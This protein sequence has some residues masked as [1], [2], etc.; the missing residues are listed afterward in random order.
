MSHYYLAVITLLLISIA[1]RIVHYD[2]TTKSGKT[3]MLTNYISDICIWSLAV[4]IWCTI[5]LQYLGGLVLTDQQS[6]IMFMAIFLFMV[7]GD[8]PLK[9]SPVLRFNKLREK[10]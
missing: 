7:G 5:P 1:C 10:T 6:L 2:P 8:S 9:L 4:E 3:W